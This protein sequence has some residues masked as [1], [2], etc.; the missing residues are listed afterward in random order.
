MEYCRMDSR[1]A[2]FFLKFA[3]MARRKNGDCFLSPGGE[4]VSIGNA[5][6]E[7][8]ERLRKG[9]TVYLK[10]TVMKKRIYYLFVAMFALWG[11][12]DEDDSSSST[13]DEEIS[14]YCVVDNVEGW[15]ASTFLSNGAAVFSRQD[16][17]GAIQ[18]LLAYTRSQTAN[19]LQ[20]YAEFDTQAVP[21]HIAFNEYT[22]TVDRYD[23]AKMDVSLVYDD[24]ATVSFTGLD[25]V[26]SGSSATGGSAE[27]KAMEAIVAVCGALDEALQAGQGAMTIQ[28]DRLY[29]SAWGKDS[30]SPLTVP[31]I[32]PGAALITDGVLAFS[33]IHQFL[34][35]GKHKVSTETG[36]RRLQSEGYRL[37]ADNFGW[38]MGN[39]FKR[40][41]L[42]DEVLQTFE[43]DV[44]YDMPKDF[45]ADFTYTVME[46]L[47][48]PTL[49]AADSVAKAYRRYQVETGEVQNVTQKSVTLS[50]TVNPES[51]LMDDGTKID[52]R[53]GIAVSSDLYE[54]VDDGDGGSMTYRFTGLQSKTDYRYHTFLYDNTNRIVH[55]GESKAFHTTSRNVM[56]YDIKLVNCLYHADYFTPDSMDY[57]SFYYIPTVSAMLM[58]DKEVEDWGYYHVSEPGD[59][60]SRISLAAFGSPYVDER[61]AYFLNEPSAT[62][63]WGGYVKYA[64]DEQYTYDEPEAYPLSYPEDTW[65]KFRDV[66]FISTTQGEY[67]FEGRGPYNYYTFTSAEVEVRGAYHLKNVYVGLTGNWTPSTDPIPVFDGI[68]ILTNNL[69]YDTADA[70]ELYYHNNEVYTSNRVAFLIEGGV[71]TGAQIVEGS[72]SCSEGMS[73]TGGYVVARRVCNPVPI[74]RVMRDTRE[75]TSRFPQL[76][77]DY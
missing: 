24:C 74:V 37:L 18:A 22:V 69:Y 52:N 6:K 46:G 64:G 41:H 9:R 73:G 58:T 35:D 28:L 72:R 31:E 21:T 16:G 66:E 2:D 48:Q 4:Q 39:E 67:Y 55:I 34:S 11:C 14:G 17:A 59:E 54:I 44:P 60:P 26:L 68:N 56:L 7:A 1:N 33:A 29:L 36:T 61:Y 75:G 43:H 12:T 50:G 3:K 5:V 62:F 45:W 32:A 19:L 51:L 57:Y 49:A 8:P 77:T 71:F 70:V 13:P 30:F 47:W 42:P 10:E 23:G 25:C 53:Y 63:Y 27:N 15:T 20:L 38:G 65:I 40:N 76:R